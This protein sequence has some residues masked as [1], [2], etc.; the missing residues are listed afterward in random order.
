MSFRATLN[1]LPGNR[2]ASRLGLWVTM[3]AGPDPMLLAEL[4]G[5][6]ARRLDRVRSVD[7]QLAAVLDTAR[8][9]IPG[10][11]LAS[12]SVLR[13]G[14]ALETLASTDP[15][16]D[17][18]DQLQD[19]FGEGPCLDA[20]RHK[21]VQRVDDMITEQ[22]WPRFAAVAAERGIRSQ[23]GWEMYN[24]DHSI[25]G[26]N[27]YSYRPH[28]FTGD[29][30]HLAGLFATHAALAMGRTRQVENLNTALATRK[31]IGQAIGVVMAQYEID[32]DK[33]FEFLVR[34]SR[35]GNIKLR[36]VAQQIVDELNEKAKAN[37]H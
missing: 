36:D 5:A 33:A 29:T 17:E 35:D 24:D 10:V 2:R 19:E 31:M 26:L 4:M 23:M 28:A 3:T 37:A 22:R 11:D 21:P 6:V 9:T 34:V 13:R 27:L 8:H 7:E 25:G 30:R 32:E 14:G 1:W 16:A 12:I 15:L 18:L 20:L